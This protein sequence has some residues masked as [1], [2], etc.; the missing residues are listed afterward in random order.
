MTNTSK[1]QPH[2]QRVVDEQKELLVK[3]RKLENFTAEDIFDDLPLIERLTLEN[4]LE[5]MYLYSNLLSQR[6][7]LFNN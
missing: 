7:S 5:V 2:Q 4:Q 3:I 1:L 6:I